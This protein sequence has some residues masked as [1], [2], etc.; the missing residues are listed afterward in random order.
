MK[1]SNNLFNKKITNIIDVAI[2]VF[3]SITKH[4]NEL[5]RHLMNACKELFHIASDHR[6]LICEAVLNSPM[7]PSDDE[8]ASTSRL[9]MNRNE[10]DCKTSFF[11]VLEILQFYIYV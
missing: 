11:F 4:P 6:N 2:S 8:I 5:W 3:V 1:N 10:Y 9:C 7:N